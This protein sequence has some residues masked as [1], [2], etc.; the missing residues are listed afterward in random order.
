LLGLHRVPIVSKSLLRTPTSTAEETA[1]DKPVTLGFV[2]C[3]TMGQ[4]AHI[5]SYAE[6]PGIRL[7]ALVDAKQEQARRVAA[8]YGIEQVYA[9]VEVAPPLPVARNVPARVEEYCRGTDGRTSTITQPVCGWSWA[10]KRQAEQFVA[11]CAGR[12]APVVPADHGY[13]D[14]VPMEEMARRYP[15]PA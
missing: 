6:V 14:L 13:R 4:M 2:G 5:A 7:K 10:S 11:V 1:M 8:R 9:S 12:A 3:G 15:V